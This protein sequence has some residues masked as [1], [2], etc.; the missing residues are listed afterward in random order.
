MNITPSSVVDVELDME[1]LNKVFEKARLIDIIA[2]GLDNFVKFM[3]LY[4]KVADS[5]AEE[6]KEELI[7]SLVDLINF[8]EGKTCT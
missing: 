7:F 8:Y 6:Q 3:S 4:D 1:F 5:H 2:V